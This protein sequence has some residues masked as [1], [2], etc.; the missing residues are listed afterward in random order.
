MAAASA[1]GALIYLIVNRDERAE[2]QR[3]ARTAQA[4]FDRIKTKV[5][6]S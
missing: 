4:E 1:V 3:A 6:A 2:D 5:L